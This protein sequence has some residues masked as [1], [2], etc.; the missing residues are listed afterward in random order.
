VNTDF[1]PYLDLNASKARFL[2]QDAFEIV[3]LKSLPLPV[4]AAASQILTP[5]VRLDVYQPNQSHHQFV[6]DARR[7]GAMLGYLLEEGYPDETSAKKVKTLSLGDRK[8]ANQIRSIEMDCSDLEIFE[9][10]IFGL[11]L[12]TN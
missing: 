5:V 10:G 11:M 9:D 12:N 6:V 2:Q 4:L 8:I 1:F 3:G 7:S